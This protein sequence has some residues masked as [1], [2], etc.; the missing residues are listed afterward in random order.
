MH[1]FDLVIKASSLFPKFNAKHFVPRCSAVKRFMRANSLVYRMSMHETQ[2]KPEDIATETVDYT[3]LMRPLLMGHHRD[4]RLILNM[5]QTPVYFFMMRKKTLDM[6]GVKTVNI[7]TS[8]NN[9]KHATAAVTIA[10][11]GMV[12]QLMIIVKGKADSGIART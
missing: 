11:D 8:T 9:T 3:N 7:R 10:G 5:D 6:I 1:T 12:L 2:H 4:R